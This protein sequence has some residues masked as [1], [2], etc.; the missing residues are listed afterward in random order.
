MI[1]KGAALRKLESEISLSVH[2]VQLCQ[3]LHL[4][5]GLKPRGKSYSREKVVLSSETTDKNANC[6]AAF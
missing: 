2:L 1:A 5:V 4:S 3:Q 6:D